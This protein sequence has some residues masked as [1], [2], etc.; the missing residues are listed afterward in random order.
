ML[1][2]EQ[3]DNPFRSWIDRIGIF[4]PLFCGYV[5]MWSW[6]LWAGVSRTIS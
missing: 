1:K 6:S 4:P 3:T 2:Q 5:G